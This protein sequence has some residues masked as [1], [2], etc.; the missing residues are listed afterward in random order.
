MSVQ[1]SLAEVRVGG[2]LLQV[3]ALSAAV[4]AWRL[5][6]DVAITL[7]TATIV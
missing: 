7:I 1:E 4:P 2:G 5:L 3:G 6:K